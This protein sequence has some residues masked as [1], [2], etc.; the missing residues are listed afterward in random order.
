MFPLTPPHQPQ[1]ERKTKPMKKRYYQAVNI[2]EGSD[3]ITTIWHCTEQVAATII[4]KTCDFIIPLDR[5]P[6]KAEVRE[7]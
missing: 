2:Y 5:K 6:R 4:S 1:T 7:G 3:V